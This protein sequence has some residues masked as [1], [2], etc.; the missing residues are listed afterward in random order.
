MQASSL[1]QLKADLVRYSHKIAALGW[2]ANHD[3]NLSVRLADNRFLI[4]PTAVHKADVR[5]DMLIIV[6]NEGAVLE[7]TR[8]PFSEWDMHRAVYAARADVHAVL[9]AHPPTTCGFAVAGVSLNPPLMAEAVVSLGAF[10]PTVPFALPRSESLAAGVALAAREADVAVLESHGVLAFG[11]TLELAYLRAELLEHQAKIRA[12]ALQLGGARPLPRDVVD[13]MMA[14][15]HKAAW[16]HLPP[17]N[18]LVLL[19]TRARSSS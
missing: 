7:G 9:H 19:Q 12:V 16:C 13:A 18:H 4:T 6:D 8:K 3:G 10:I 2:I 11:P 1:E 15:R 5:H 17:Q 14:A